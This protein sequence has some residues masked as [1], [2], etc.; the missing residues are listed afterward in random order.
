MNLENIKTLLAFIETEAP[1]KMRKLKADQADLE[2]RI[3]KLK[4]AVCKGDSKSIT[5]LAVAREQLEAIPEAINAL[6]EEYAT[7]FRNL[8][9]QLLNLGHQCSRMRV[10][11][12]EKIKAACDEFLKQFIESDYARGEV[13]RMIVEVNIKTQ[14]FASL[15]SSFS[16]LQF[17]K[18][19]D[20]ST[21]ISHANVAL[22]ELQNV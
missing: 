9:D 21:L 10:A 15:A 4:A 3:P 6:N 18:T 14:R 7:V 13:A 16:M 2:E 22:R 5:G 1:N 11:E 12:E 17:T 20:A 19:P 8:R